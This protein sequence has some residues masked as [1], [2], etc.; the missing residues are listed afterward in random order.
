MVNASGVHVDNII[1]APSSP[2]TRTVT[3]TATEDIKY[4][5]KVHAFANGGHFSSVDE[6]D[7]LTAL[8]SSKT[9]SLDF[10]LSTLKTPT[11]EGYTFKGWGYTSNATKYYTD[12]MLIT[13]TSTSSGSPTIYNMYA[14]W[15]KTEYNA[16]VKLGAGI[17]SA[18]VLVD[19]VSKVDIR[20]SEYHRVIVNLTSTIT[21]AS[22]GLRSG[23]EKPYTVKFYTSETATTPSSSLSSNDTEV[24]YT[25]TINRVYAEITATKKGI[26]LFYWDGANGTT[27][28]SLIATGLLV[29]NITAVRWNRLLAKIKELADACGADFT[30]TPVSSG[31]VIS[32]ARFNA[33]RTGL[34][35]IN[36]KLGT[37]TPLPA[38]QSSG[39]IIYA[40]LFN[41]STSLK[42][43]L[44]TLIGVY[45]N[46]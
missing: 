42:G 7:Y 28:A 23:Y 38:T 17:A 16:Y 41:G 35:K 10:D 2:G 32:A 6:T 25:Y 26:D 11:R 9:M 21:I 27:D 29:S 31:D 44:N 40:I 18:M 33:A 3:L 19:G 12:T 45:N 20:D 36:T 46:G 30:Y 34:S 43:A 37:S 24:S 39:G 13:V 14:I 15:E 4:Y 5:Y 1:S 22:I 8:K